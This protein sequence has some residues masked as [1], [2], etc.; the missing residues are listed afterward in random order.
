MN[1]FLAKAFNLPTTT[2]SLSI[3]AVFFNLSATAATFTPF[4][5]V[6]NV[7][8]SPNLSSNPNLLND[9]TLDVRLD[10]VSWGG[11]TVNNFEVVSTGRVLQNDTYFNTADG[12][13][14]GI[15][16][17]G[18]GPNTESDPL[19]EEGPAKPNPSDLDIANSLGNLNLN[20]LLVTRENGNT[21]SIEVSFA[22]PVNTFFFWER[23]GTP[24]SSVA[25]D[26][27]L[28]VEALSDD[29]STVL[30][31]YKILR[32]NYTKAGYNIS[33][34]VPPVLNNGPFNI[35]SIGISLGD[36]TTKTL[37]LTSTNNNLGA[38]NGDNGPDFKVVAANVTVPEP[39]SLMA[40]LLATVLGGLHKSK[41]WKSD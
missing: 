21:A 10:S 7:T 39:G 1:Q 38:A 30:A 32:A 29:G 24:G 22:N 17:S 4:S 6:T 27:D 37:R 16:H 34:I 3:A 15:L 23:G 9:P 2:V 20:S 40:L 41:N 13:T 25:G 26:S 11:I 35:G 36:I 28:L 5:F 33:T 12:N 19:V 14:Y 8:A 31:T 18:H